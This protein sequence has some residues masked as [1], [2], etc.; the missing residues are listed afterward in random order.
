MNTHFSV[1]VL[2]SDKAAGGIGDAMTSRPYIYALDAALSLVSG[3]WKFLVIWH[4]SMSGSLRF[5]QLRRRVTGI[6]E[7]VLTSSLKDLERAGAVLRTDYAEQPPR[8]EYSLTSAGAELA[9]ALQPLSQWGQTYL[10][11]APGAVGR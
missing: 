1:R 4:L 9:A 6:S 5:S 10:L 3:R 11:N 7:K 8:V 2:A